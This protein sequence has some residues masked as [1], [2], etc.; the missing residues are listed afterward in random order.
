MQQQLHDEEEE[1][2]NGKIEINVEKDVEPNYSKGSR[3]AL[4]LVLV[5]KMSNHGQM[6]WK[7]K[8]KAIR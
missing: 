2:G 7:K 3:D 5:T 8:M 4:F 1:D 6:M